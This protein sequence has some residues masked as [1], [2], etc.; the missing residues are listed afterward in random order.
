[1]DKNAQIEMVKESATVSQADPKALAIFGLAGFANNSRFS[2]LERV[3]TSAYP[4]QNANWFQDCCEQI[5]QA[6]SEKLPRMQ[7]VPVREV[8]G[9]AEFLPVVTRVRRASYLGLVV[10]DL[11]F[12]N[13]LGRSERLV[14]SEMLGFDRF[15]WKRFNDEKL[16]KMRSLDISDELKSQSKNRLPLLDDGSRIRY[17]IHRASIDEFIVANLAS[18]AELTMQDLLQDEAARSMFE[19]TFTV[20]PLNATMEDAKA[21]IT[22]D[23]RDVFITE[24]GAREE[25]VQGWLTNVD[26]GKG[27]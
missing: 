15:Y 11:Y 24:T 9:D 17:I 5:V 10:F 14:A 27:S 18:A 25:P 13:A 16:K 21:A 8:G 1:M 6:G 26:L 3:W 19:R 23:I 7:T 12:L 20:I 4:N 22:G 2:Q